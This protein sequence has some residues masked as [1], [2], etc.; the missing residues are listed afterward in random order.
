MHT[1]SLDGVNGV[2]TESGLFVLLY[3]P[4]SLQNRYVYFQLHTPRMLTLNSIEFLLAI[5]SAT[6]SAMSSSSGFPE[7]AFLTMSGTFVT[8]L[9]Q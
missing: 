4:E 5:L 1:T 9:E 8:H 2:A 3:A 6:S 7:R